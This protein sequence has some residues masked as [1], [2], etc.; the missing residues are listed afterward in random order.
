MKK[1]VGIEQEIGGDGG[2]FSGAFGV[3]GQNLKLELAA[4]YPIAKVLE[5][6]T[7][8]VDSLL[9]KVKAAVPGTWD[10]A[11]IDKFKE[12]YKKELVELLAE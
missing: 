1:I 4:T 6:A 9:D 5:P 3:E 2:K 7:K 11:L 10:D 8:A 12:E